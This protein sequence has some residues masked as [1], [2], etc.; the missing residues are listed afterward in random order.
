MSVPFIAG[1]QQRAFLFFACAIKRMAILHVEWLRIHLPIKLHEERDDEGDADIQR[2]EELGPEFCGEICGSLRNDFR[3]EVWRA[4]SS[5]VE[6]IRSMIEIIELCIFVV[7]SL[8][9]VIVISVVGLTARLPHEREHV[10]QFR[11]NGT[12]L[13]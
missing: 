1:K 12:R 7:P 13:T 6:V 10:L 2:G 5:A 11:A 3:D 8:L 4:V 9:D